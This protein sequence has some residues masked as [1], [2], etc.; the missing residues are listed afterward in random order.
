[1]NNLSLPKAVSLF[2]GGGGM[3]LGVHNAGFDVLAAIE[4][5]EHCCETLRT[6]IERERRHTRVVEADVRTIRPKALMNE[7]GLAPGEL[8]LLCGGP[9]CQS[10]SQIGKQKALDDERGPLLFEMV[11]FARA[12]KPKA[13]FIEQVKGLAGAKDLHGKR[14]GVLEMLLADI[15]AAGYA[16][17]WK[18]VNAADYGLPQRRTR[19]FVVATRAPNGFQFPEQT[20]LPPGANQG[21]FPLPEHKGVGDVLKGLGKPSPKGS[22]CADSHVDVTPCGDQK[23][24][25]G[26]PEGE[27]L[28]AQKHLPPEQVGGL[29][30]KDTTKYLRLSRKK[31]AN[32]LRCGEIFFHP[33]ENRYL[34]PREYMRIHGYPDSYI[35]CGPIRGRAGAV[36]NLDQHRQVSNSVPPPVAEAIAMEIRRAIECQKSSKRSA[37]RRPRRQARPVQNKTQVK[38]LT[39]TVRRFAL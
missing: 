12:M 31:P 29:T 11:R 20:H 15:E 30:R 10:F 17:K 7:L 6:N 13:I 5:D 33:T 37:R 16:P 19:L 36:R 35:L 25:T 39:T 27:F 38:K 9:P 4:M 8:D 28:A 14:G 18:L 21:L 2:S 23:R 34:T 26:V 32:T 24:I 1:M 22:E 3:D